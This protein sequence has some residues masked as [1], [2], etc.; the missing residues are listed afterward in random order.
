MDVR[1]P[2]M[3]GLKA[4]RVLRKDTKFAAT[5]IIILTCGSNEESEGWLSGADEYILKSFDIKALLTLIEQ[6][7][8]PPR[9][10]N[11]TAPANLNGLILK[12]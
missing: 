2:I 9:S 1:M 10:I 5:K 11:K 4:C 6:G 7:L 12:E 3:N 8:F